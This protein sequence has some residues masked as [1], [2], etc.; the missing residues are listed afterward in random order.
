MPDP[1]RVVIFSRS[2]PQWSFACHDP[3]NLSRAN[4]AGCYVPRRVT[5]GNSSASDVFMHLHQSETKFGAAC[6]DQGQPSGSLME[7]EQL[8]PLI[9]A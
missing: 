1:R 4:L 8:V 5:I 2:T 6:I 9:K 7:L 3:G